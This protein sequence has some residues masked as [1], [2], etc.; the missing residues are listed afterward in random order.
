VSNHKLRSEKR[1]KQDAKKIRQQENIPHAEALNL[2]VKKI[3]Y[4]NYHAYQKALQQDDKNLPSIRQLR[5]ALAKKGI[6]YAIFTPTATGLKKA[7]IDAIEPV[8]D[9]F[10]MQNFHNYQAQQ[11]GEKHKIKTAVTFVT[12]SEQKHT[13]VSLY[14]PVTKKGDPRMW[15][16]GLKDFASANDSIAI[17]FYQQQ[18]HL[19]NLSKI[20]SLDRFE[21]L[22]DRYS[23]QNND[24]A[25]ELLAK[26]KTLAKGEPL[27][28]SKKGDTAI[29]M[30][31]ESALGIPPNSSK[32]PDYKGIELK[33]SRRKSATTR[34]TL[35]AQVAKWSDSQ[36]KSSREILEKYG[37]KR[38]D[39][40][41]LYCTISTRKPNSQGLM[42]Q[43]EKENSEIHELHE[44]DGKV[45]LWH[46]DLIK[47]RLLEKHGETFWIKAIS[48]KIDGE[49]YF[50]LKSVTHTKS[51]LQSQI[52][53][54][55]KEGIITIDHLIKRN[56]KGQI[57]EK[58][59][60]FKI[61][62]KN[63]EL[64]FPEPIEYDLLD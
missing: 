40:L 31:V 43:L 39:E 38:G 23:F 1:I 7:I 61:A 3:G 53:P 35:F 55:I 41:R 63:L 5:N 45:V 14:R 60:L 51:P 48:K 57:K 29:G 34:G 24:I 8:R 36:L 12:L 27:V 2:A 59:P 52:I 17:I 16:R 46:S 50:Y 49:E 32:S 42:L 9:L 26:L 11:Q 64:L 13:I 19:L 30:A 6:D 20:S 4:P 37:Y 28:S 15:F 22:L 58:G 25:E 56:I 10:E 18:P 47:S 21:L 54:L 44:S 33:S 62:P